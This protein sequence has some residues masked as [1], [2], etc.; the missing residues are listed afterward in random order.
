MDW[1]EYIEDTFA[2]FKNDL[3]TTLKNDIGEGL[4]DRCL[5]E[6]QSN[7][8]I[9]KRKHAIKNPNVIMTIIKKAEGQGHPSSTIKGIVDKILNLKK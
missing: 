8:C 6:C 1:P 3:E 7:F 9:S 4:F 2:C 5:E